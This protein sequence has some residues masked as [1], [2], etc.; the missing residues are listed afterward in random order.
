MEL[1]QREK[2]S[3]PRHDFGA[4]GSLLCQHSLPACTPC[5]VQGRRPPPRL[6]E[7]GGLLR[8]FSLCRIRAGSEG[9]APTERGPASRHGSARADGATGEAAGDDFFGTTLARMPAL[10]SLPPTSFISRLVGVK[11]TP[12]HRSPSHKIRMPSF[13]LSVSHLGDPATLRSGGGGLLRFFSGAD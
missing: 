5:T 6:Q 1:T 12:Q 7:A 10:V 13:C 4:R 11:G 8:L 2:H 3:R 9:H